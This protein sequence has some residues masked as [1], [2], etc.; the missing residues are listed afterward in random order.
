M[1]VSTRSLSSAIP[2]QAGRL[3][4]DLIQDSG[5]NDVSGPWYPAA[6]VVKT[7]LPHSS[8]VVVLTHRRKNIA[9][10]QVTT[11]EVAHV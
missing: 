2:L 10:M 7:H 5:K 8:S 9:L 4:G 3:D 6:A 1:I 11:G